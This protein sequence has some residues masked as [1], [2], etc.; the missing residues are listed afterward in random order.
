MRG[1]KDETQGLAHTTRRTGLAFTEMG[2]E[3][4][5]NNEVQERL[6]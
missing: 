5:K 2:E 6:S 3:S 1:S 4:S